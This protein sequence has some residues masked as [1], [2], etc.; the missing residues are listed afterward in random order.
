MTF[1]RHRDADQRMASA[2]QLVKVLLT[3]EGL[4]PS[5]R[6][7]FIRLALWK[8]T[9]AEGIS[10]YATRYQSRAARLQGK[11]LEHEHVYE[12]AKMARD[13]IDNPERVD[14]ILDLA[15]GCAVTKDEHKRLTDLR[16][17]RC[18]L[19]GRERYR[20]AGITVI[21]TVTDEPLAWTA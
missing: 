2:R 3:A 19:D 21:D 17:S 6:M 11:N 20:S 18:E 9:E 10:K 8:V 4:Y 5:H 7:E 12:R 1:Q 16:K 14:E 13:L 15:V